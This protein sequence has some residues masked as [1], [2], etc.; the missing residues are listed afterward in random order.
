MPCFTAHA[1][2]TAPLINCLLPLPASW[3]PN[4]RPAAFTLLH[5]LHAYRRLRIALLLLP[6]SST[7]CFA[8]PPLT[9][10]PR[11]QGCACPPH[12]QSP[13][14]L[15]VISS[16]KLTLDEPFSFAPFPNSLSSARHSPPPS[17]FHPP[18]PVPSFH[19]PRHSH[20][21]HRHGQCSDTTT[22]SRSTYQTRPNFTCRLIQL[23]DGTSNPP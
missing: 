4:D 14:C 8:L 1:P 17:L 22:P 7:S 21:H 13:P 2:Y 10:G 12:G 9:R 11:S 15:L 5:M 16:I 6:S 23:Q 3:H 19:H 18:L 20:R